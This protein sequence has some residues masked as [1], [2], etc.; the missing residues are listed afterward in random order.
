MSWTMTLL[1]QS[2]MRVTLC[3][4]RAI[5]WHR[6][7]GGRGCGRRAQWSKG[8]GS[9]TGKQGGTTWHLG[10]VVSTRCRKLRR[11]GRFLRWV[12]E[13]SWFDE[14]ASCGLAN[15]PHKRALRADGH[16]VGSASEAESSCARSNSSNRASAIFGLYGTHTRGT[17]AGCPSS[18]P[19]LGRKVPHPSRVPC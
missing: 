18:V 17:W 19:P 11:L 7:E 13:R 9:R 12:A 14:C 2:R 15:V 1:V 16:L 10:K 3:D 6:V 4:R 8:S 5:G